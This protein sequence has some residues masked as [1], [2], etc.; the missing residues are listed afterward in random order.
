MRILVSDKYRVVYVSN[1]KAASTTIHRVFLRLAG[2]EPSMATRKA[3]RNPKIKEEI[4]QEGLRQEEVPVDAQ[5]N[6]AYANYFW[7]TF[8]RDP[9][10][11]TISNYNDKLNRYAERFEKRMYSEAKLAQFLGGPRAWQSHLYVVSY[12]KKRISFESYLHGLK[13]HGVNFDEHFRLQKLILKPQVIDYDY[14]GKVETFEE[15]I[16]IVLNAIGIRDPAVID[17]ARHTQE[18]PSDPTRS[19]EVSLTPDARKQIGRLYKPDFKAFDY[20]RERGH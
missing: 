3:Y 15:D 2:I 6:G 18:N 4:R 13:L 16:R 9:H 1:P 14:V 10:S 20:P 8:V 17:S 19:S 12:L 7:C 5:A 11:R